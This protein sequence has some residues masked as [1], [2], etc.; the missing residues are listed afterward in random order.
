MRMAKVLRVVTEIKALPPLLHKHLLAFSNALE[1]LPT[2]PPFEEME[3]CIWSKWTQDLFRK[4][5]SDYFDYTAPIITFSRT[6]LKCTETFFC[7]ERDKKSEVIY[8]DHTST[9]ILSM[10]RGGEVRVV[11]NLHDRFGPIDYEELDAQG[12]VNFFSWVELLETILDENDPSDVN[13]ALWYRGNKVQS[14]G[15]WLIDSFAE[16][17][18]DSRDLVEII[19]SLSRAI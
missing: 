8:S 10:T 11:E 3:V 17:V 4:R 16:P 14:P 9:F 5:K 12:W 18:D 7:S 6:Q 13:V 2:L 19:E 1:E 15:V